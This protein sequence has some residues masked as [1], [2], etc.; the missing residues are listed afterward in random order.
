MN[1]LLW[2]IL[3]TLVSGVL[4]VLAAGIFLAL[5]AS[6]AKACCRTW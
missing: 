6:S 5:P 2:I 1:T 3:A 4:S